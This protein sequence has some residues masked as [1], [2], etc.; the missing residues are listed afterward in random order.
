MRVVLILLCFVNQFQH[1]GLR[2]TVAANQQRVVL[3]SGDGEVVL[4]GTAVGQ[5][6]VY[7][8]LPLMRWSKGQQAMSGTL[9]ITRKTVIFGARTA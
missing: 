3:T 7:Y 1:E 5:S 9:R 2:L 4:P 8:A 6:K